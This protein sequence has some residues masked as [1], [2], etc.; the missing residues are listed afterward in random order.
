M[1]LHRRSRRCLRSSTP[2]AVVFGEDAGLDVVQMIA[3]GAHWR[4]G[5]WKD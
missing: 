2:R 4:D 3:A 5:A 1:A